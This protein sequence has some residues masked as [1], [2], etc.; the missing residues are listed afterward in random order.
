MDGSG[1]FSI[2]YDEAWRASRSRTPAS[3]SMPVAG[4][5][6]GD[7]VVR[8]FLEGLLPDNERVLQRWARDYQVSARNP[9]ALLRHVGE[10]C[11]GGIQFVRPDRVDDVLAG[12]G[13]VDWL[14]D[15]K[16]DERLRG[17]RLDPT[18]WHV[19][20]GGQFSLAGAQAKI[21]LYRHPE[22][23]RWGVPSGAVPTTHIL[24][25]AVTGFDDHDLNEHLCL[26]AARALGLT[27]AV[28]RIRSFGSE[29]AIVVDRYDR[30]AHPGT[31]RRV[32]QEDMCQA[33]AVAPTAKYQSE[34]GPAP[35]Q[36]IGLLRG[37]VTPAIAAAA[38]VDRF[39]D[40]LAYN[41]L[42][43]GTDAHAKNYSVLLNGP[44]VRLA[45]MYDVASSL[46]Y[47]EFHHPKLKMAMKIG[48]EYGLTALSGRHWRRFATANRL[49]PERLVDRI[50][51]LA[52]RLPDAFAS[53]ADSDGVRELGSGLPG[54]LV[55]RVADHVSACRQRLAN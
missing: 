44:Q 45:P 3:L 32:H 48:G 5:E 50:D 31:V 41:W 38:N 6:H 55:Q 52:Q 51:A 46:A 36:I 21:A 18:A 8:P 42:I 43:G 37:T 54:R 12:E 2:T 25:P 10:D 1:R 29:R 47:D 33:L 35:E 40:A 20:D 19:R 27:A 4:R 11:A 13:R 14:D 39:V 53:A 9:F 7:S 26:V 24:K 28:T 22:T 17:L 49:D 34:G 15:E 23:G 30:V 16:V